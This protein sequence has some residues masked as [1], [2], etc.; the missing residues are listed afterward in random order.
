MR[1]R[2]RKYESR[3]RSSI[4]RLLRRNDSPC[5]T[6]VDHADPSEYS[7]LLGIGTIVPCQIEAYFLALN[8]HGHEGDY[9]LD[10]GFGL[11][12]GL[13]IMAIKAGVVDGVE[14]DARALDYCNQVVVGR[15]PRLRSLAMY[16]GY[17]LPY[18]A[19][20]FDLVTCVDVLEHVPDYDRFLEELLRVSSRGVFISTPNRR[21]EYTLPDGTPRNY[22]H[23]REWSYEELDRILRSHGSVDWHFLNGPFDGPFRVSTCL[24]DDT[25]VLAPFIARHDASEAG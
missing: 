22:W 5:E 6:P 14:V 12:Y 3:A 16:D 24:Q 19:A 15:N 13:N 4:G 1:A 2:L 8:C 21:S 18:E 25:L 23:L 20:A 9:I 17:E 7:A 11:G 10:V